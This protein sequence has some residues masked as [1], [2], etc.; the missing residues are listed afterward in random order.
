M[1]VPDIMPI[2]GV[3]EELLRALNDRFRRFLGPE[4]LTAIAAL[5][6]KLKG[7]GSIPMVSDPGALHES[8]IAD[9]GV[10]VELRE[11]LNVTGAIQAEGQDK[12]APVYSTAASGTSSHDGQLI[13]RKSRGTIDLPKATQ[14]G[15][16]LGRLEFGGYGTTAW[17]Y[18]A[19]VVGVA[20]ET[21]SDTACGA[22]LLFET[23]AP[24][25]A[26]PTEKARLTG[27]GNFGI[28]LTV[29][30]ALLHLYQATAW[31]YQFKMQSASPGQ[32]W[33]LGISNTNGAFVLDDITASARRLTIL[34]S[35]YVG[36]GTT[37]PTALLHLY[38]ATAGTG[39][40]LRMESASPAGAYALGISNSDGAFI[41]DDLNA[42]ARR[43]TLLTNGNFGVGNTAP[44]C[45]LD[46]GGDVNSRGIYRVGA[47]VAGLT[48]V[49]ALA[50]L[51]TGG[52]SGS[53]TFTGGILTAYSAPS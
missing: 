50:K 53:A 6:E 4:S 43:L 40:L 13:A 11:P 34:T 51:T 25:T 15:D 14:T 29:P 7:Q 2:P 37:A 3:P 30:T 27:G 9:N 36:I 32:V 31:G 21:F 22:D 20:D 47:G 10:T 35:G 42:S 44:G 41:L 5:A 39:Y 12:N 49:V 33:G 38:Q 8:A 24:T 26:T 45:T 48:E 28:G 16:V 17:K 1:S 46:V 18:P 19:Q 23:T 52:A